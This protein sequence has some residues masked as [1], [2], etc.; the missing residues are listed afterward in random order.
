MDFDFSE[1]EKSLPPIVFRNW[2]KWGD[3]IPY[4]PRTLANKDS[5]GGNDNR[6]LTTCDNRILTTPNH[7]YN[8]G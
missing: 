5:M 2:A 7:V 8:L 3:Y 6:K 4:S 1:L